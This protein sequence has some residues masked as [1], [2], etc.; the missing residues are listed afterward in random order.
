M[1]SFMLS[2]KCA[3]FFCLEP[4]LFRMDGWIWMVRFYDILSMQIAAISCQLR[5]H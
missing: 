5:Y 3:Q 2:S 4:L 1:Q